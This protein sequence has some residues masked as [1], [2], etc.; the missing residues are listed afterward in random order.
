MTPTTVLLV[1]KVTDHVQ[2]KAIASS[3]G[4][5]VSGNTEGGRKM[6]GPIRD[7]WDMNGDSRTDSKSN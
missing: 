6:V 2:S 3:K 1:I 4:C 5:T 7:E